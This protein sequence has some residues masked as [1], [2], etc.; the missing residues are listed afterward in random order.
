MDINEEGYRIT[1]ALQY[2]LP[3]NELEL[4]FLQQENLEHKDT[5]IPDCKNE[6]KF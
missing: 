6:L 3:K 5:L 1:Y 2:V 4:D